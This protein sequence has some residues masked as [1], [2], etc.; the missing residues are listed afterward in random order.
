MGIHSW[1]RS[2]CEI[3]NLRITGAPTVPDAVQLIADGDLNGWAPYYGQQSVDGTWQSQTTAEGV[4]INN[5]RRPELADTVAER[6]LKYQRPMFEDGSIEY[7]FFYQPGTV[8][9]HP[10][11][12]RLCF[13]LS[14][15]GVRH[16]WHTDAAAER[17]PRDCHA[18][19][20]MSTAH[21][22][23][24]RIP[25]REWPPRHVSC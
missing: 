8:E 13:L 24:R 5:P 14:P 9:V 22:E 3:M 15:D 16:H 18:T 21:S 6:V 11:L 19:R 7:E 10:A 2:R 25:K 23:A 17:L 4:C 12:G 1:N 20:R